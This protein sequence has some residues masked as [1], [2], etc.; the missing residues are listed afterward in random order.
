ML[1]RLLRLE[2]WAHAGLAAVLLTALFHGRSVWGGYF[3]WDD[4]A[5]LQMA[6]RTSVVAN[7]IVPHNDHLLPLWR[8]QVEGLYAL[9]GLSP[10]G[11][12]VVTLIVFAGVIFALERFLAARGVGTEGRWLALIMASCWS[13]WAEFT[14]GYFTLTVYLQLVLLFFVGVEVGR[15][16]QVTTEPRWLWLLA[17][18]TLIAVG[19]DVS[20]FWVVLAVPI[21]SIAEADWGAAVRAQN[22]RRSWPVV[23]VCGGVFVVTAV[24]TVTAARLWFPGLA[25]AGADQ[26]VSVGQRIAVAVQVWFAVLVAPWRVIE[27]ALGN[28]ALSGWIRLVVAGVTVMVLATWW[29]SAESRARQLALG[30]ATIILVHSA[31]IAVGRPFVPDEFPAKHIGIPF[32]MFIAIVS[33]L[34]APTMRR[35]HRGP[36]LLLGT[37]G[38]IVLAQI[39]ATFAAARRGYP[40]TTKVELWLAAERERSIALLRDSV[41]A[42]LIA[43]GVTTIPTVAVAPLEAGTKDLRFYDLSVYRPFLAIPDSLGVR[44]VRDASMPPSVV[45]AG[46]ELVPDAWAAAGPRFRKLVRMNPVAQ[47]FWP[48]P[49]PPP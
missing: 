34:A 38:V 32:L 4:F 11:Y 27:Y 42:P 40:V 43:A 46:V 35:S 47:R 23:L 28:S 39:G 12:I 49:A 5:L 21:I 1:A 24:A 20:G 15:R 2:R 13:S 16:A 31:M 6:D 18:C 33:V 8:L 48:L 26:T 19:I 44:F 36:S 37:L 7:I 22:V 30:L 45:E 3:R 17:L 10:V 41:V 25:A 9:F 14:T 29:R